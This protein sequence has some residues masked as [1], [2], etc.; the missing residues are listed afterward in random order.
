M[1]M[2]STTLPW[3]QMKIEDPE[4]MQDSKP[5]HFRL[6]DEKWERMWVSASSL[7]H[8]YSNHIKLRI[9]EANSS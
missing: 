4:P 7:H 9:S 2:C 3:K 6:D 5:R 1:V 8:S